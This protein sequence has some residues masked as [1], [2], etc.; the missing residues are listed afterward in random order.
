MET[1]QQNDRFTLFSSKFLSNIYSILFASNL[2]QL[3]LRVNKL[4]SMFWSLYFFF[5]CLGVYI[6]FSDVLE[7]IYHFQMFWSLYIVFKCFRVY[8]QFPDVLQFKY[9][10][11]MFWSLYIVFRCFGVYIQFP[12]VL[13]FIYRFQMFWSVYI[14][15]R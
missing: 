7:F 2:V 1:V 11:Q 14:V 12:D 4:N 5:R 15:F 9:R 8:I 13:E 6:S 3:F 10:F